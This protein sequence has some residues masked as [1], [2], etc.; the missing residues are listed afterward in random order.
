[1]I[2]S[3]SRVDILPTK[4][5]KLII[6]GF[7]KIQ[8]QVLPVHHFISFTNV[9]DHASSLALFLQVYSIVQL[10]DNIIHVEVLFNFT[11]FSTFIF[12][13]LAIKVEF[14]LSNSSLLV[15][16]TNSQVTSFL[17]Y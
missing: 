17:L 11:V 5:F 6:V 2:F 10:F 9:P 12:L 4:S 1:L 3:Q 8:F 14:H 13:N 15:G 16:V 7:I